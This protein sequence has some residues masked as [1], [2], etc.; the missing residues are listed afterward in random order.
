MLRSRP[1]S[2][3]RLAALWGRFPRV[4]A[5]CIGVCLCSACTPPRV[6]PQP[7]TEPGIYSTEFVTID[8]RDTV[9]LEIVTYCLG[10][11][12]G[13]VAPRKPAGHVHYELEFGANRL[14]RELTFAVWTSRDSLSERPAQIARTTILGDSVRTEVWR[15]S[16]H[17]VQTAVAPPGSFLWVSGYVGLLSHLLSAFAENRSARSLPL[18]YVA[19][20]GHTGVASIKRGASDTPII[21][22][23]STQVATRWTLSTGLQSAQFSGGRVRVERASVSA[24][25]LPNDRCGRPPF[26]GISRENTGAS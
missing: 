17:Q 4:V 26:L 16:D 22:L 8:G 19:T 18:F 7:A 6:T 11:L 25:G 1:R 3:Q 20:G 23:D 9:A 21:L 10:R 5:V 2:N 15:G 24:Q 13:D 12:I 14:P